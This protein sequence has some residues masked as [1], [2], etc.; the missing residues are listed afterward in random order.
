MDINDLPSGHF[1]GGD[2]I[3]CERCGNRVL[4]GACC[5]C[6]A[7]PDQRELRRADYPGLFTA[8]DTLCAREPKA[9]DDEFWLWRRQQAEFATW[10][11][12]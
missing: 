12:K 3:T 1:A 8:V 7:A 11:T 9:D 6:G 5:V 10:G 2:V 4:D